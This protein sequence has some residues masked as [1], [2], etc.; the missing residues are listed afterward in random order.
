MVLGAAVVI[1]VVCVYGIIGLAECGLLRYLFGF[2]Q[3]LHWPHPLYGTHVDEHI[4]S[5]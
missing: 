1:V 2:N 5:R 3:L 4:V